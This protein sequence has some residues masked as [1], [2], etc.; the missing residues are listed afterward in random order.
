VMVEGPE[1]SRVTSGANA[2]AAAI[3]AELGGA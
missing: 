3:R 1:A 2:I